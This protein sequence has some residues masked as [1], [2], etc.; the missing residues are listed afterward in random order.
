MLAFDPGIILR[1]LGQ[2]QFRSRDIILGMFLHPGMIQA[3]VVRDKIEQQAQPTLPQAFTQAGQGRVPAQIATDG[4]ARDGEP[5]AGNV[6]FPQVRQ[7]LVKFLAPLGVARDTC[8]PARP[9]CHTLRNQTQS[10][11]SSARRSSSASG[12]SSSVARLP[13]FWDNSVSQTRV[14]IWY[15]AG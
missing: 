9:V 5:R 10:N 3:G 8:C 1:R 2:I 13:S 15:S 12:M 11:P 7:R 14:L 6:F 4:V